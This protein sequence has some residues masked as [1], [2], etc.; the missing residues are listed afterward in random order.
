MGQ[1]QPL[2]VHAA[3]GERRMN[4]LVIED[5]EQNLYLVRF[6][7]EARGHHVVAARNGQ[8]GIAAARAAV[9]DAILL[10]M[11]LP[12]MDGYAVARA[13]RDEPM[14]D[15]VPMVAVTSYAMNGDRIKALSAGCNAYIEKPINP[16]TFVAQVEGIVAAGRGGAGG[17]S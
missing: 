12:Q 14:L 9:P 1:G 10:D 6:L 15:A 13:L 17:V 8:D 7:L 11:Q 2:R 4:I 3:R 5:N 16:D